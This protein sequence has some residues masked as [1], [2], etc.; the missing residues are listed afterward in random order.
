VT[1]AEDAPPPRWY[2]R[3]VPVSG[4]LILL[5]GLALVVPPFRNQIELSLT[6]QLDPYVEL[7]FARSVPAGGQAVCTR[8]GATVRVSFVVASHLESRQAVAWNVLLAPAGK[9][10][11]ALS[12]HG[13]LHTV[14]GH[15][16]GM[17]ASF[18][19][20]KKQGYTVSVTLPAQHQ[21]LR[22]HCPGRST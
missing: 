18:S 8:T 5:V 3:V 10:R 6:R 4:V 11:R 16:T 19:L 2:L 20:P 9:A 14:P 21:Q 22:A 12:Q 17:R 13:S 7:Y 1:S 15:A